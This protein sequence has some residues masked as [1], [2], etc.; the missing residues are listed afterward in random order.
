MLAERVRYFSESVIREMTRLANRHGAINLAQGMPDF[1]AAQ[2]VKDAACKAIQD[3]WNQYAVT[4]GNPTLRQAIA[5]KAARFNKIQADPDKHITVCCGATECMM[6]TLLAVINPGDEVIIFQPFYENYGPDTLLTGAQPVWVKLREPDWSFDHDELK[7]AFSERTR[8]IIINTPNNPTGKVFSREELS[9][10]AELCILHDVIAITDEIYE[11][12]LYDGLEHISVA[13][14]P[15]MAD[16]TVTIS[17][18][19]KTFSVTGW[20]LGYCI[21]PEEITVGIRRAHD[22]LTVG[23]PHPLQ[24]A[25]VAAL[26][27]PNSYY[28]KLTTDYTRRRSILLPYLKEA[29]F[30]F[31]QP[32][33]AYYVMTDISAF[34]AENDIA[35]VHKLV[36]D[37][38]VAGVPGS[39]FHRPAS[40]GRQKVRFMWAKKDQTLH[41]A[42]ERLLRLKH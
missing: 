11:H 25:A 28:E 30:Q 6:A 37:T 13:S 10:I 41:D 36:Q 31:T 4:W 19:S 9:Y 24:V 18:M 8:A 15:G 12:I 39:S 1:D 21:A 34:G 16:R 7:N 5:T 27:L 33:G 22:F 35:F 17:G 3:G 29:G 26:E 38:G 2:P 20:R 40:D 42:G 32:R 23:A 14:L